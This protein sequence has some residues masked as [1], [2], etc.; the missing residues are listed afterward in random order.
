MGA[1]KKGQKTKVS[2]VREVLSRAAGPLTVDDVH[3]KLP[4]IK[5]SSLYKILVGDD[6]ARHRENGRMVYVLK[7]EKTTTTPKRGRPAKATK[8]DA[9]KAVERLRTGGGGGGVVEAARALV[10]ADEAFQVASRRLLE[11]IAQK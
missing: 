1:P 4:D 10:A 6:V 5:V 8:A 3:K 7:K 2:R 9:V 11:L